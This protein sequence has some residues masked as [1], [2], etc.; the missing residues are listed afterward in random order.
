MKSFYFTCDYELFSAYPSSMTFGKSSSIF[1]IKLGGKYTSWQLPMEIKTSQNQYHE[2]SRRKI[3]Q[4]VVA[5]ICEGDLRAKFWSLGKGWLG[6]TEM[7]WGIK[8]TSLTRTHEPLE[9]QRLKNVRFAWKNKQS[10]II[11]F[12]SVWPQSGQVMGKG[13]VKCARTR[14]WEESRLNT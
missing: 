10:N 11:S 4:G 8:C 9:A 7:R 1:P 6:K 12:A 3:L 5:S 2:D 13:I 14:G